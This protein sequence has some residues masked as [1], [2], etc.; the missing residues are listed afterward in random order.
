MDFAKYKNIHDFYLKTGMTREQ[1]FDFLKSELSEL[2]K[3][4]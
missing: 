2:Q 1:A 4:S 3:K